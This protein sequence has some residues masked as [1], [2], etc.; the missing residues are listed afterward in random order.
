MGHR[1]AGKGRKRRRSW[2]RGRAEARL[3]ERVERRWPAT[4]V[5]PQTPAG[6]GPLRRKG[7]KNVG[8]AA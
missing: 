5:E 4:G 1:Q 8:D 6:P 2:H 3:S 7:G